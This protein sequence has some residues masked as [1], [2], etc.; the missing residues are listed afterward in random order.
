MDKTEA[1]ENLIIKFLEE[2]GFLRIGKLSVEG[3]RNNL[4]FVQDFLK[5]LQRPS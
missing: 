5:D 2:N 1:N 4:I 3:E